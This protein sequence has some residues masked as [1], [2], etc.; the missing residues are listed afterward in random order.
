MAR[1]IIPDWPAMMQ[2]ATA[3]RY[4]DMAPADFEREV[5]AQ[6]PPQPVLIG[7]GERWNKKALDAA[8]DGLAGIGEEENWRL[9]SNLYA[10][11]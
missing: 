8:I 1:A 4:C 6:R 7:G 9:G 2:R 11:G 5:V 10:Q 3:A